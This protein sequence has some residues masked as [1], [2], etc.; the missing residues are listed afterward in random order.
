MGE[1]KRQEVG[2]ENS[3]SNDSAKRKSQVQSAKKVQLPTSRGAGLGATLRNR[4]E[5]GDRTNLPK[6]VGPAGGLPRPGL[7]RGLPSLAPAGVSRPTSDDTPPQDELGLPSDGSGEATQPVAFNAAA[8]QAPA[9]P[10]SATS[11]GA[12][13]T[14]RTQSGQRSPDGLAGGNAQGLRGNVDQVTLPEVPHFEPSQVP[15]ENGNS[16]HSE[17]AAAQ[18]ASAEPAPQYRPTGDS[19]QFEGD[20]LPKAGIESSVPY[21]V[22]DSTETVDFGTTSEADFTTNGQTQPPQALPASDDQD[23]AASAEETIFHQD[24]A[25]PAEAAPTRASARSRGTAPVVGTPDQALIAEPFFDVEDVDTELLEDHAEPVA[26]NQVSFVENSQV[27]R[28][29]P[30]GGPVVDQVNGADSRHLPL[31]GS[32]P[33]GPVQPSD[34]ASPLSETVHKAP[35]AEV[36]SAVHEP[37]LLAGNDTLPPGMPVPS[38][39]G[40]AQL[41][42]PAH[43][44]SPVQPGSPVQLENPV[45]LGNP[46][47]FDGGVRSE[48]GLPAV[49]AVL[50]ESEASPEPVVA[51]ESADSPESHS[52]NDFRSAVPFTDPSSAANTLAGP[53]PIEPPAVEVAPA[54]GNV[55]SVEDHLLPQLGSVAPVVG[56]S[57][58]TL[59]APP[60]ITE[61]PAPL[62]PPAELVTPG[63]PVQPRR[64][65]MAGRADDTT[66][67]HNDTL[68]GSSFADPSGQAPEPLENNAGSSIVAPEVAAKPSTLDPVELPAM[69]AE[70]TSSS[71]SFTDFAP[72]AEAPSVE[73][74]APAV[75]QP[76]NLPKAPQSPSFP[77]AATMSKSPEIGVAEQG[78]P[79]LLPAAQETSEVDAARAALS[80]LVENAASQRK[81][82]ATVE[83]GGTDSLDAAN[84]PPAPDRRVRVRGSSEN[85]T[86]RRRRAAQSEAAEPNPAAAT[87]TAS[88][89]SAAVGVAAPAPLATPAPLE[90]PQANSGAPSPVG[91]VGP[92]DSPKPVDMATPPAASVA[93]GPTAPAA[94]ITTP[95]AV[96]TPA[97]PKPPTSPAASAPVATAPPAP[98]RKTTAVQPVRMPSRENNSRVPA[99]QVVVELHAAKVRYG[100][101]KVLEQASLRAVTGQSVAVIGP[102]GAGKSTLVG[103]C[104][105]EVNISGGKLYVDGKLVRGE[106]RSALQQAGVVRMYV[107]HDINPDVTVSQ[108]LASN[109]NA[110]AIGEAVADIVF[111]RFPH[112]KPHAGRAMRQL[113]PVDHRILDLAA[114]LTQDPR[115]VVADDIAEG[116]DQAGVSTLAAICR[117]VTSIGPGLVLSNQEPHAALDICSHVTVVQDRRT[118]KHGA[119]DEIR[120]ILLAKGIAP[121]K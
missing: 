102:T 18:R 59:P 75:L 85:D 64:P 12:A 42:N 9:R 53:P 58:G 82:E 57:V 34:V 55:D 19:I 60:R 117:E 84:Y 76:G 36:F 105:G 49:S 4:R 40:P 88:S 47:Q 114:T 83:G 74:A 56:D 54:P 30:G 5:A 68:T 89:G 46:V 24:I 62:L 110:A 67:A 10:Q 116:L 92:L 104:V 112:L 80:E 23:S 32:T 37:E 103:C 51:P 79:S 29:E 90:T 7:A 87:L 1:R 71:T 91:P 86:R 63:Q 28:L 78:G 115:I 6:P 20:S 120:K 39:E 101:T 25:A 95:Q 22:V 17:P 48:A 61:E 45:Q 77:D 27:G 97:P 107:Q 8:P 81:S 50:A 43:T 31:H 100:K 69:P 26:S 33:T 70:D 38:E 106:A 35:A 2:M 96:A 118:V 15:V 94:A 41:E 73:L 52:N 111:D 3:S 93:P 11:T 66:S 44:A 16:G 13:A 98:V 21:A 113:T 65:G 14:P 72:P 108:Y 119:S 121:P 99:G 109:R